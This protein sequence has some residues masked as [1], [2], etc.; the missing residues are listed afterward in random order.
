MDLDQRSI[1]TLDLAKHCARMQAIGAVDIALW[2]ALGKTL[3]LPVYKLLGGFRDK[4]PII[5]I[6]GYVMK[7]KTIADLETEV[8]HYRE[9]GMSGM[10][11]KVGHL[12]VEEDIERVRRARKIGWPGVSFVR[13]M[14][15]RPGRSSRLCNSPARS[16]ILT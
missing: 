6:G 13:A 7:G 12:S 15:T 5:A 3:N 10:K 4:V 14:P 9:L 1:H 16:A 2:D 8:A 11:L